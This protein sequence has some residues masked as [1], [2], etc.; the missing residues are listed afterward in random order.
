MWRKCVAR[1]ECELRQRTVVS[2]PIPASAHAAP[3]VLPED[4]RCDEPV[5]FAEIRPWWNHGV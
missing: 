3:A 4:N 2:L 1:N 5:G